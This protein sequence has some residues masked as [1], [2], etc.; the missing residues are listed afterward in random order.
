MLSGKIIHSNVEGTIGLHGRSAVAPGESTECA[1][2]VPG[3]PGQ[4]ALIGRD[5][6]L[7]AAASLLR[8]D[9]GCGL[10]FVG[11]AGTGKSALLNAIAGAAAGDGRQLLRAA[12]VPAETRVPFAGLHQ[13]LYPLFGS[14]SSLASPQRDALRA[15]FGRLG[16]N[17]AVDVF[18]IALTV[19]ELLARTARRSGLLVIVDDLHW[20]D[21]ATAQVLGI[22]ARRLACEP[23]AL[24]AAT[25]PGYPDPLSPAGLPVRVLRP[26]SRADAELLVRRR[27][28]GLDERR[29]AWVLDQAEGNPLALAELPLTPGAEPGTGP[30]I[31][32]TA[33]LEQSFTARL[34][35]LS[36]PARSAVVV[37]AASDRDDFAEIAAAVTRA[38]PGSGASPLCPAVDAGMLSVTNATVTFEH[39]LLRPAA[40]QSASA[41]TRRRA[42]AALAEVLDAEPE[43]RAWHRAAAALVPDESVAAE[44]ERAAELA[45]RRGGGAA[46]A[47]AWEQAATLSP[48]PGRRAR[49]L[50][51]AAE[52]SLEL[53]RLDRAAGLAADAEP[54]SL[55]PADRARLTLV[56]D[57]LDPG[58]PG[59]PLRIRALTSAAAELTDAGELQLAGRLLLAAATRAWSADPGPQA[60]A[61][62]AAA[63]KRLPVQPDDPR[64]L[65]IGGFAD[66]AR[67]GELITRHVA[68]LRPGQL[69]PVSAELAMSVQLVGADEAVMAVQRAVTDGARRQG[70][71]GLLPRLLTRQA[72]NA[73]ALADC[74]AA[75]AAA[76]E[77]ASLAA[78]LRQP[79]WQA[80]ALCGQAMTAGLRGEE[81]AAEQ[82]LQQAEAIALPARMAPVL[83][84][85][86]LARG[87][88]AIGAGRYDEAFDHLGRVFDRTDPCY[89]AEHS[90]WALGDF[91]EAAA[92]TGRTVEAR[93]IMDDFRPGARDSVAPWTRVAFCYAGVLLA[94][95]DVAGE[96]FGHALEAGLA[97]WPAYRAR[98]L[99]E[100]GVRLRRRRR[101][102]EARPLLRAARQIC[103]AHGLLPWAERARSELRAAGETSE[104]PGAS[105]R[106][107]LS[108]Q[109]LRI[110]RLAAA[111]L[112][113]REIGQRLYLSHRTV[114]SH[115]YRM[116]PKLGITSRTQLRSALEDPG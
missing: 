68:A 38:V 43:R 104:P 23:A 15:V 75:V 98:L 62:L 108:P 63:A 81:P 29:R 99:L 54:L 19:L 46:C 69:D 66:P 114:S 82:L 25:R 20:I 34:A 56:R 73:I 102:A 11:A 88:T 64:L 49:R 77:A 72:W 51:Q 5:D 36:P 8:A 74:P 26:L 52:V 4:P 61:A 100:Y 7:S 113:N 3:G 55:G 91:A 109:E 111:G 44:L 71:R 18:L 35:E 1:A 48:H 33:P 12:G 107:P 70:R 106:I 39:P 50:L 105:R 31:P 103:E 94:A 97:R 80:A 28:P 84:G 32:L 89:H 37:A 22:V 9:D 96:Q 86:Q 27:Y 13:L 60:R 14:F 116:F 83:C 10:L 21:D 79:L 53:G 110:A 93:K 78:E 41:D 42:H 115:L 58:A 87:V 95:D 92:R 16:G 2:A 67:Y 85:I 30:R 24:V 101:G 40:Y 47:A 6:E 45:A 65:S 57:T 112:S 17:P 76:T 90:T 59:D